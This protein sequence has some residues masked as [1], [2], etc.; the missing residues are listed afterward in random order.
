MDAVRKKKAAMTAVHATDGWQKMILFSPSEIYKQNCDDFWVTRVIEDGLFGVMW[1]VLCYELW[2]IIAT[3]LRQFLNHSVLSH[4]ENCRSPE[5]WMWW[6]T[7]KLSK[8][9]QNGT[10]HKETLVRGKRFCFPELYK[11][12]LHFFFILKSHPKHHILHNSRWSLSPSLRQGFLYHQL[13]MAE[14]VYKYEQH[15]LYSSCMFHVLDIVQS[16]AG[17]F[18]ILTS[19]IVCKTF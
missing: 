9:R 1:C 13:K 3:I 2:C 8:S 6:K 15:E 12:F 17:F 10:T 4:Q 7:L 19:H 14:Q 16:A 11:R 5:G 18:C